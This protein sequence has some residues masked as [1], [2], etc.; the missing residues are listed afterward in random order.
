MGSAAAPGSHAAGAY[1][2]WP[3]VRPSICRTRPHEPQSR[4]TPESQVSFS[5][6]RSASSRRARSTGQSSQKRHDAGLLGQLCEVVD[7]QARGLA[8]HRLPM[9]APVGA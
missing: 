5:A 8:G 1:T 9:L 3:H 4:S 6:I 7:R 2:M